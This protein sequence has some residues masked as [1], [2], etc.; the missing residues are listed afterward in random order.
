MHTKVTKVEKCNCIFTYK[1]YDD[2]LQYGDVNQIEDAVLFCKNI[3]SD[4]S[5]IM[6]P[7]SKF[8]FENMVEEAFLRS[9]GY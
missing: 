8:E 2:Y 7:N 4:P 1:L 6:V 3:Y 5:K 9:L